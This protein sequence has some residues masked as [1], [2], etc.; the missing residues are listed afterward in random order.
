MGEGATDDD[1]FTGEVHVILRDDIFGSDVKVGGSGHHR[2]TVTQDVFPYLA[3]HL[4]RVQ[5][6]GKHQVGSLVVDVWVY[7]GS[8]TQNT[9]ET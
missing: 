2:A 9:Q 3:H 4:S 1:N 6:C 5:N 7:G 8:D